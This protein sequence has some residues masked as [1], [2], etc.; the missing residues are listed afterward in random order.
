MMV[1]LNPDVKQGR[2]SVVLLVK[3]AG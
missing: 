2:S 1:G 3:E